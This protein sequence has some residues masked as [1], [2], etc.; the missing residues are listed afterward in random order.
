M[1]TAAQR[2][3]ITLAAASKFQ[4]QLQEA[5]ASTD[6]LRG[7]QEGHSRRNESCVQTWTVIYKKRM[8]LDHEAHAPSTS[9]RARLTM[10]C[11]DAH[12]LYSRINNRL[13]VVC[14]LPT[15]SQQHAQQVQTLQKPLQMHGIRIRNLTPVESLW[16]GSFGPGCRLLRV[17]SDSAS[18]IGSR[19][20]QLIDPFADR[21]APPVYRLLRLRPRS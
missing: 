20:T 8:K 14:R 15:A 1:P 19:C 7:T 11:V 16:I 18:N 10:S 9:C 13:S 17:V 4:D 5:G 12:Q 3:S 6:E 2:I 21:Q